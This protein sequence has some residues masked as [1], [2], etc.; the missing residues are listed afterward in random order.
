MGIPVDL[1]MDVPELSRY[2]AEVRFRYLRGTA[3]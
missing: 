1:T 2:V 3:K